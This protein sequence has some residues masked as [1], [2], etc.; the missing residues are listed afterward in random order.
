VFTEAVPMHGREDS[1]RLSVPPL[2]ALVLVPE[3]TQ[4]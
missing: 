4:R 1:V 2:G 3:R